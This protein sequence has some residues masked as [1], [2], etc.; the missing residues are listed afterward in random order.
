MKQLRTRTTR[1]AGRLFRQPSMFLA[2]A[3]AALLLLWGYPNHAQTVTVTLTVISASDFLLGF[4]S[5]A[6][7]GV[8][9]TKVKVSVNI[10]RTGAFTGSVTVTPPDLSADGIIA[11]FP[12]SITTADASAAWKFKV[13]VWAQPGPHVLRFTAQDSTGRVRTA[14]VTL[15]LD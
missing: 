11:K 10:I 13:K 5:P 6:V 1:S 9:G 7:T 3:F 14:E 2:A 8:R 15:M 12:E 4:D